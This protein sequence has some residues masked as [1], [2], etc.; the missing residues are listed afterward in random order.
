MRA[1]SSGLYRG[2]CPPVLRDRPL[3]SP[4]AHRTRTSAAT[5]RS[6][7]SE[8]AR[9]G[10]ILLTYKRYSYPFANAVHFQY[11]AAYKSIWIKLPSI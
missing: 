9:C 8:W 6:E 5:D 7:V 1:I 10:C 4:D 11:P 2:N 3:M